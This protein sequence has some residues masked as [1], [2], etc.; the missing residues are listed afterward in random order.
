MEKGFP[1]RIHHINVQLPFQYVNINP[2]KPLGRIRRL[3][4]GLHGIIQ[5]IANRY[6]GYLERQDEEGVFVTE[7]MLPLAS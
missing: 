4:A 6:H 1:H 3:H 5:Q 7:I 2:N